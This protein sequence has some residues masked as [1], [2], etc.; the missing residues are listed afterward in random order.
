MSSN[1][2]DAFARTYIENQGRLY[3]YITTLLPHRDDAEDVLQRTSL[4]LWQK[5]DQFDD[6]R[7]FLPWARGIALNEVRNFLRRHDRRNTHLSE[8]VIEMLA[9]ELEDDRSEQ[10]WAAL[11][12]CLGKLQQRQRDLVEQ[13]Y[14]GSDGVKAVASSLKTTTAAVYMRLHRVR[15]ILVECVDREIRTESI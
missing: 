12:V 10:R 1:K 4:I 9:A 11:S 15:K 5:W 3:G 14:L 13:C 6:E 2:Q 8:P 7:R